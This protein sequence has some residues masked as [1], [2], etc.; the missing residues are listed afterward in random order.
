MYVLGFIIAMFLNMNSTCKKDDNPVEPAEVTPPA[1]ETTEM[2]NLSD[3]LISAF[4][5]IDKTRILNCVSDECKATLQEELNN[6]TADIAAFGSAL[7]KRTLIYT[8]E[9]YAEY[10]V[11][12]N[13]QKYNVAYA[14]CGDSKW[15][16]V[17]F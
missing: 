2:T 14:N 3:S 13:G 17:R 8:S 12:V 1:N 16:V 11:E 6:T 5:S 4:K 9:L 15:K 10:E 7:E